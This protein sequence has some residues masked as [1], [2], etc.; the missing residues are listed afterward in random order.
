MI[1]VKGR[2][3]RVRARSLPTVYHNGLPSLIL[4]SYAITG[5]LILNFEVFPPS[6]IK[7]EPQNI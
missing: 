7:P 2:K 3:S 6:G 1:R 4:P 5:G